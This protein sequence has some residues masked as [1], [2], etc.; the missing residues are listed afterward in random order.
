[1]NKKKKILTAIGLMAAL[2]L[3][4]YLFDKFFGK[5][6]DWQYVYSPTREFL[7]K[8]PFYVYIILAVFI[9]IVIVGWLVIPIIL[10]VKGK[11]IEEKMSPKRW[12]GIFYLTAPILLAGCL[13]LM[14]YIGLNQLINNFINIIFLGFSSQEKTY[15]DLD[16]SEY[17]NF[18][19]ICLFLIL[20]IWSLI[21]I[22][23]NK[24]FLALISALAY[25]I[26]GGFLAYVYMKEK[27]PSVS[28]YHYSGGG[29][30]SGGG[31]SDGLSVA[32]SGSGLKSSSWLPEMDFSR[33]SVSNE[34]M[35]FS[36]GG[37]KDV[38]NFRENIKEN[39]LPLPTDIT[40]EGLFYDY[41]FDT[42]K[43]EDCQK[44]FCPSYSYAV[45]N[46]PLNNYEEYYL[47]VGLNS[48]LKEENF[49]RKK[50]NLVI[51]LDISGSMS[52]PF[53]QYYYDRFGNK[54]ELEPANEEDSKKSKIQIA[55]EAVVDLLGHLNEDD[56]FGMVLFDDGAYLAKPLNKVG[57]TDM[58]AI[59]NH[60]LEIDPRGG[61]NMEAGFKQGTKSFEEFLE[62]DQ[63][64]YENRIIFLTD[65]MPN[66][67]AIN[68]DSLLG[69][70]QENA[71]NKLYTTF[72]GI[73]IDFNTELIEEITKVRGANYYSVHSAEQFKT[74]MDDEFELMVTPL[75]FNLELKLKADGY[76]IDK[77]YG[78]PEAD[79]A[80]GQIM[81]VNT[82]FPSRT[83]EGETR[84][85]LVLLKLKKQSENASLKLIASYEDRSGNQ[86]SD[87]KSIN[88]P[89]EK[90]NY[91]ENS[92]I[93]KGI[94]LARYANL[95]KK[96][97][98]DQRAL[99]SQNQEVKMCYPNA[100]ADPLSYLEKGIPIP[101]EIPCEQLLNK[102]ERQSIS[103][104]IDPE[105][106]SIF[107][108]FKTYFQK[109]TQAIG[110][111]NLK[112]EIEILDQLIKT[113][114]KAQ[115]S[116]YPP[117]KNADQRIT[118]K[119]F[120]I[121]VTPQN[122]PIEKERFSGYHTGVD[123][124]ILSGEEDQTVKVFSI[125]EGKIIHKDRVNGY[126]GVI[127]QSCTFD[128]E[129][130]SVLYGH[131]DLKQIPVQKNS[132]INKGQPIAVLGQGYSTETDGERK[133]LHLGLIKGGK[134]DFKGYVSQESM[135]DGWLDYERVQKGE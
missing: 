44:L 118:K 8:M 46:D 51:V 135:L 108:N 49:Q 125:C 100:G 54:N 97:I 39:K 106:K 127:V 89:A 121:F 120:G 102:W 107:M 21:K 14:N 101:Q 35:G 72:I 61:T 20:F 73:G 56:R 75:V 22:F 64:E 12:V 59:K 34:E 60:I 40:Y 19:L 111:E 134:I 128:Q 80:T 92:G 9:V 31:Y 105:Y 57:K 85:G 28:N 117:L 94:L 17:L 129:K 50:L 55:N 91:Y 58:E 122:S 90:E 86:D 131:L 130:I 87:Q 76:Q 78:S 63:D 98:I 113:E 104:K 10:I 123:F 88:F 48:N 70:T 36:V 67:G 119:P 15:S 68:E 47:S 6:D 30:Y 18:A 71:E 79:E 25:L 45:S 38:N 116:L 5:T 110:D 26:I 112:Q 82:L 52:S 3:I 53:S 95:I 99:E 32:S 43:K 62:V 126:G 84:G 96:W 69:M 11:K 93:R 109:E 24:V 33:S 1:M 66:I 65:A 115:T 83:V 77:V 103:L 16:I 81:K 133:H 2:G 37:A 74:R 13:F 124:E 23:K 132:Q 27:E 42:G 114:Q 4:Y 7:A 41:Y 29:G